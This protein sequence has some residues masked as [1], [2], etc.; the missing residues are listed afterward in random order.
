M[1]PPLLPKTP[2]QNDQP[3]L[4]LCAHLLTSQAGLHK[5]AASFQ[6]RQIARIRRQYPRQSITGRFHRVLQ[7]FTNLSEIWL[8]LSIPRGQFIHFKLMQPWRLA[9][10]VIP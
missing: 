2:L 10:H 9:P 6:L 3:P 5:T 4:R 7:S 1:G 8:N